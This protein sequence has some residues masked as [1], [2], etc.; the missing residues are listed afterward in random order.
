MGF[1]A[2]DV[3]GTKTQIGFFEDLNRIEFTH[4]E[5]FKSNEFESLEA[6]IE[7]FV[8]SKKVKVQEIGIGIA[9]PELEGICHTTN[10]PW[11]V[12]QYKIMN[13]FKLKR[14]L[15]VNDLVANAYGLLG[16]KEEEKVVVQKG[17]VSLK[18]NK[19]LISPGTGL[20][21]AG[22][23]FDGKIYHPF[24]T[25]GGH[26]DFAPMNEE[27]IE[28]LKFLKKEFSHVSYERILSGYGFNHLYQFYTQYLDFPKVSSIE[29]ISNLNER[30]KEITTLAQSKNQLTC[31]KI[32]ETFYK[33][34][35]AEASNL[36]LKMYAL[37]GIYIGG[38]II[39]KILP[40]LDKKRFIKTFKDKGRFH[41]WLNYMS[42]TVIN[43]EKAALKG[44]AS[45][46][47][48]KK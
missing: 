27:E 35:A 10:L 40:L 18:G 29:A 8:E 24:P 37:G 36:A 20:G 13:H 23:F 5:R 28:L 11:I 21:E 4:I 32:V 22:L 45:M 2:I 25:E 38:G 44:A 26:C 6:I 19:G 39:T 16:L 48:I 43:D 33:I 12:D 31:Q 17:I 42:I 7:L 1:L 15:M 3:G 34:L 41:D 30:P 9:G 47:K 46:L 14:C